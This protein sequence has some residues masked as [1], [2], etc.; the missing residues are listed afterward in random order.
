MK[1][2]SKQMKSIRGGSTPPPATS[3]DPFA[4]VKWAFDKKES[5]VP[6]LNGKQN[7]KGAKN[8]L[9]RHLASTEGEG[10]YVIA[11]RWDEFILLKLKDEIQDRC[12]AGELEISTSHR[13]GLFSAIRQTVE[14]AA[15]LGSLRTRTIQRVG[16]GSAYPETDA[17]NAYTEFELKQLVE[18]L[19]KE[20][21]FSQAVAR[22]PYFEPST[23]GRDPRGPRGSGSG[24]GYK[25]ES[26]M[27]WYFVNV[28]NCKPVVGYGED[29]VAHSSFL[30]AATNDHGGLHKLYRSWGVSALMDENVLMPLV[31]WLNYVTGI[32]PSSALD[33]EID[34]YQNSHPLTGLPYLKL[35]KP[36]SGGELE[37]HITLLDG[38]PTVPLKG[39]Q[40]LWVKRVVEL[41][42]VLTAK[43]RERLPEGHALAKRLF[44]Y[45]S[46]GPRSWGQVRCI[47][48]KQSF[49]WRKRISAQYGLHT[50]DGKPMTF[51]QVR[52]RSTLLT[53]MV[54][55]GRDL[56]EVRSVAMHKSV[57]TTL[58]Y[59]NRRQVDE[60]GRKT[61]VKA[62]EQIR[63]NRSKVQQDSAASTHMK[64]KP[65]R[66]FKA[67][68]SDCL[69]V[70]DPPPRVRQMS[71]YQQGSPCSQFN[72]CLLCPNVVVMKQHL[73]ML[74]A[75][76]TQ[77]R[78][79]D[80][81]DVPLASHY[82]ATLD[83]LEHIFDPQ[84]GEFS[85]DD[86]KWAEEQARYLDMV[87]DPLVYKGV[88][89]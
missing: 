39:K 70:Y 64:D 29:K 51:N 82:D 5:L 14:N 32:N 16:N 21:A 22:P 47:S 48:D 38:T 80:V 81:S 56:L 62:L 55:G 71:S 31:T 30:R 17:H 65:I 37:M 54:L 20:L 68:V 72:M 63:T 86:I 26:N 85:P 25:S 67:I 87:I 2:L 7:Y 9:I 88:Q 10:P 43:L 23:M 18:V 53:Q 61:V 3:D 40:S 84:F 8:F 41:T 74:A 76:R 66:V 83:V 46:T 12:D 69:N 15:K 24:G 75:Y 4:Q 50:K 58:R 44:L 35:R 77:I 33:L 13:V 42:L 1:N 59:V 60:G 19:E 27:R 49:L 45:E 52:F 34:S 11:E 57:S 73:P 78:S 89:P 36:R 79:S 6:S 28:L